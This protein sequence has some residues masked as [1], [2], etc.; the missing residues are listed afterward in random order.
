MQDGESL[1]IGLAELRI[2]IAGD[3]HGQ[4]DASDEQLL[5]R[6]APDALL[7]VGESL[8]ARVTPAT[9]VLVERL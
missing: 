3:L 8:A 9:G 5:E 7:L 2:A 4:W 6:L 1:G